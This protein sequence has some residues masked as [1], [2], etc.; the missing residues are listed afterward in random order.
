MHPLFLANSPVATASIGGIMI[1]V[2]VG[3]I[4]GLP[5]YA[6]LLRIL[7]WRHRTIWEDLGRPKMLMVSADRSLRLQSFLFSRQAAQTTDPELRGMVKFLRL[8]T[9]FLI[10]TV[11]A[12]TIGLLLALIGVV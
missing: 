5:A 8:F 2:A 11:T 7:R 9:L 10:V 1:A 4:V 6:K 12:G 3:V